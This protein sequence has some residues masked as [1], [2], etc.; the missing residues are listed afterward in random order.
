[1]T[2]PKLR[3]NYLGVTGCPLRGHSMIFFQDDLAIG[4]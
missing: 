4:V 3:F 2:G 1:M